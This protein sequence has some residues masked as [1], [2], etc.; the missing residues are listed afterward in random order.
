MRLNA[1]EIDGLKYRYRVYKKKSI[2]PVYSSIYF[3]TEMSQARF[4]ESCVLTGFFKGSNFVASRK[5]H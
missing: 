5:T 2:I 4:M 1:L 3:S